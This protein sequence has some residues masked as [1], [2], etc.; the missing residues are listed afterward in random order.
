MDYKDFLPLDENQKLETVRL[1]GKYL[2]ERKDEQFRIVLYELDQFYVQVIFL[3]SDGRF[4][5][6]NVLKEK[7]TKKISQYK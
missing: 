4:S 5:G 3:L 6:I 1:E 2:G 7:S